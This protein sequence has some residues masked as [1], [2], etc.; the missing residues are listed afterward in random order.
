MV[1]IGDGLQGIQLKTE[2]ASE[3]FLSFWVTWNKLS[4]VSGSQIPPFQQKESGVRLSLDPW[5]PVIFNNSVN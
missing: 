2:H 3:L 5:K 4:K 1:D